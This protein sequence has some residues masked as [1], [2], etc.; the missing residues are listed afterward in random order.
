[1]VHGKESICIWR[2]RKVRKERIGKEGKGCN[3]LHG[4][5]SIYIWRK[6]KVRKEKERKGKGVI[7]FSGRNQYVF[8][9]KGKSEK[10]G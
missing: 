5:E 8:G 9:G 6:G 10:K 4:T 7:G 3:W 2:K 1:M